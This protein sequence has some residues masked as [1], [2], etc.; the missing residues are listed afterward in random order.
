MWRSLGVA[1]GAG[2]EVFL[3]AHPYHAWRRPRLTFSGLPLLSADLDRSLRGMRQAVLD[4]RRLLLWLAGR[5][6]GP[7]VLLGIDIGGLVAGVAATVHEGLSGLVLVAPH[8]HVGEMLWQGQTDRGR[9]R[10]ALERAGVARE[11]LIETF[12]VLDPGWRAPLVPQDKV[13]I[14][15]GRYDDVVEPSA[16]RRLAERWGDVRTSWHDFAHGSAALAT[17]AIMRESLALVGL[18]G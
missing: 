1:I 15:A 6:Q 18:E 10:W 7:I 8:D 3:P 13:L 17:P 2:A 14:V 5:R 9:I 16:V 11:E 12:S 4:V